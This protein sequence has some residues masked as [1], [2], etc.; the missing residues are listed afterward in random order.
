M[1]KLSMFSLAVA[2]RDCGTVAKVEQHVLLTLVL[3]GSKQNPLVCWPSLRSL[4]E[5]TGYSTRTVQ[6]SLRVLTKKGLIRVK[7]RYNNSSIYLIQAERLFDAVSEAKA[8]KAAELAEEVESWSNDD[9]FLY[10]P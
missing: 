5:T 4:S 9:G 7:R 10:G 1:Q 3:R 2:T 8:A 6:R